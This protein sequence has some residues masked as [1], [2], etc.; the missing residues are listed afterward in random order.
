MDTFK[1]V[2]PYG[3]DAGGNGYGMGGSYGSGLRHVRYGS[4]SRRN[5]YG[6]GGEYNTHMDKQT[7]IQRARNETGDRLATIV[8]VLQSPIIGT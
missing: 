4:G 6:I 2:C 7:T 8:T 1:I 5:G 3:S